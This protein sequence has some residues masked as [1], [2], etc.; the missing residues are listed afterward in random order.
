MVCLED[1]NQWEF[2]FMQQMKEAWQ[3]TVFISLMQS[4]GILHC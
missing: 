2:F 4:Y 1:K 3:L